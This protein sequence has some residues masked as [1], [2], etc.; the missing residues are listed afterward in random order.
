[1]RLQG[2]AASLLGASTKKRIESSLV[3]KEAMKE[4]ML[5]NW[6]VGSVR[7]EEG[8]FLMPWLGEAAGLAFRRPSLPML[9]K[10]L[11]FRRPPPFPSPGTFEIVKPDFSLFSVPANSK[12][13]LFC[14]WIGHATCLVHMNGLN[15]L[16][17]AVFSERCSPS[18][19]VGPKR[20]TPPACTI[21]ELPKIDLVLISHDHYDHL[22]YASICELERLHQPVFMC[23]LELGTW[24]TRYIAVPAERVVE[25]DWWEERRVCND[26]LVVTFLPVQHWSKRRAIGDERRSLW[27]GFAVSG[28]D[29]QFFFNGD[30]GYNAELYEELGRRFNGFDL[31]AIPIGAYQPRE[32]MR[33]QHINPEEAILI[34]KHLK[35]KYSIGIHHATFILTDEPLKEPAERIAELS[36]DPSCPFV[37]LKHGQTV[38][39]Q[40][41]K[42]DII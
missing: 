19:W 37:A 31:C 11:F 14:T 22:D 42:Y 30:T 24:F 32:F 1:L 9:F 18:Q 40:A 20:Y 27:G 41:G 7:N 36:T 5:G 2:A 28:G 29:L 38:S 8:Q 25:M 33:M 13:L 21:A 16:T 35:S 10:W 3:W 23:G 17:D 4:E 39:L 15:I 26:R 34:H 6:R 12:D